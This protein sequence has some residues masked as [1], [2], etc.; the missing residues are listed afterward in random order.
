MGRI[1][2]LLPVT[3][4]LPTNTTATVCIPAYL[5][6]QVTEQGRSLESTEG[7]TSVRQEQNATCI[8][9]GSGTYTFITVSVRAGMH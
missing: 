3:V 4:T 2:P 9:V 6:K 5:G 1:L 7:V 8:E